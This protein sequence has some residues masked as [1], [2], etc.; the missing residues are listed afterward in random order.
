MS[1]VH[2]QIAGAGREDLYFIDCI[3]LCQWGSSR[4][5]SKYLFQD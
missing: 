5:D 4:Q 1:A 2:L 3:L